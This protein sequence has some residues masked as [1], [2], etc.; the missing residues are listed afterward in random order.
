MGVKAE[1]LGPGE[2]AAVLKENLSGLGPVARRVV[3]VTA[4]SLVMRRWPTGSETPRHPTFIL[5]LNK[6]A[7]DRRSVASV[8]ATS[9]RRS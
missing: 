3:G 1:E 7:L 6:P 5:R 2:A 4:T 9:S 8:R